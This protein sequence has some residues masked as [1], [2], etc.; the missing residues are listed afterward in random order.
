MQHAFEVMATKIEMFGDAYADT[1]ATRL[2][3]DRAV[4]VYTAGHMH[5]VRKLDAETKEEVDKLIFIFNADGA[6]VAQPWHVDASVD[7]ASSFGLFGTRGLGT[8]M[9]PVVQDYN[10]ETA[11]CLVGIAPRFHEAAVNWAKAMY[12]KPHVTESASSILD[13]LQ[14][15]APLLSKD[16]DTIARM[17]TT[18]GV[19]Q[20]AGWQGTTRG[21]HPHR[22]SG[23]P[24]GAFRLCL[25]ITSVG[26]Y[27]GRR[28]G[29]NTALQHHRSHACLYWCRF[30]EAIYWLWADRHES[31]NAHT[32]WMADFPK[33]ATVMKNFLTAAHAWEKLDV[34]DTA[35]WARAL[36]A[37]YIVEDKSA[38]Q[39]WVPDALRVP[40]N[41]TEVAYMS[42]QIKDG[43]KAVRTSADGAAGAVE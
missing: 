25:L 1:E 7:I 31:Y 24:S 40:L 26:D 2:M 13:I 32:H 14:D 30:E 21:P 27:R 23:S 4:E 33:T 3:L 28:V 34:K 5:N 36:A 6:C 29:Y 38:W 8:D 18:A 42:G 10:V 20:D 35:L 9:L 12:R 22:G 11:L 17:S 39:V 15:I 16:F 37:P 43:A 41:K 19:M